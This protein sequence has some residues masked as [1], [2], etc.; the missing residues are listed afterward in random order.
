[1][2]RSTATGGKA[3]IGSAATV[4]WNGATGAV[5]AA[6]NRSTGIRGT[7]SAASRRRISGSTVAGRLACICPGPNQ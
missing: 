1:M 7:S 6:A 4:R 3:S 5:A 2:G